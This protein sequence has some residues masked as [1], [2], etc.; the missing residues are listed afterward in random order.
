MNIFDMIDF[1]RYFF[2]SII[3]KNTQRL[4]HQMIFP[5]YNHINIT[6]NKYWQTCDLETT[7][8]TI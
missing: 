3:C 5:V 7:K 6:T 4:F 2:E 8:K 1:L